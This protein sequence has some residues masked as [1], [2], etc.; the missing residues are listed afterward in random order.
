M[1]VGGI[2]TGT[3]Y[4]GGDGRLWLWDIFNLNQEGIN[5]VDVP[6]KDEV[7]AGKKIRS[8]DGS[9]YIAPPRAEGIMPLEQG[10]AIQLEYDGKKFAATCALMIGRKLHLRPLILWQL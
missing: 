4:L 8:R 2:N 5:P 9:A 3:L 10:F 6:W 7:H 1:P